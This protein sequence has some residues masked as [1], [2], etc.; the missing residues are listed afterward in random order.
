MQAIILKSNFGT[1]FRFGEALGAST[2]EIHN[3]P[4]S[5]S[6][7]LHSD[8]LWSALVNAWALCC[9]E[10]VENFIS[11]CRNGKLKLSSA[12]YCVENKGK[13]IYFLPKPVSLNL[14]QYTEPRRLKKVRFISKGVWEGGLLPEDWFDS[15]KC[16][17]LQNES[18]VALKSEIDTPVK[19][20]SVETT[21]KIHARN[22]ANKDNSF[23]YET[24]LFLSHGDNYK[25]NWYFLLENKL[26]ENLKKD[27]QKAMQT[28]VNLGIGGERATGSGGLSGFQEA[29]LEFKLPEISN[30]QVSVSLIAPDKN[31]LTENSLYQIIK[32]GGR[33][34]ENGNCLPMVQMLLEGAV[35]DTKIEGN[36]VSLNDNPPIVR[37][38]LNLSI[39]LHN[40]FINKEL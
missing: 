40:N 39:P 18:V 1:R 31:E 21:P 29:E 12:F 20:F 34:L 16:T 9:P 37:Y 2:E 15:G 38:G 30:Y 23:Y 28:L 27:F 24:N 7:Y 10:T 3:T 14:F 22:I 5:T 36:I 17:L 6:L 32:R 13:N 33:L 11:E 4:K 19:L 25:V 8:T 26:P 35:F